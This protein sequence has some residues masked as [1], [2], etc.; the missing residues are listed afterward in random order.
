MKDIAERVA[1]LVTR[2]AA[3]SAIVG[4]LPMKRSEVAVMLYRR[5]WL[6]GIAVAVLVAVVVLSLS[7]AYAQGR[8]GEGERQGRV[9]R[10]VAM[11]GAVSTPVQVTVAG[12]YV[13]VV[14]GYMLFQ[15]KVQGLELVAQQDLR[16]DEEKEMMARQAEMMRQFM[17][18]QRGDQG[19]GGEN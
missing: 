11:P 6:I 19:G 8:G 14:R 4:T 12:E 15:F 17:E 5:G 3:G 16:T 1:N 10:G 2:R 9:Q 18:R 13:Y 7:V